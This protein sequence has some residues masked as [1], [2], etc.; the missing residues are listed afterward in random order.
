MIRRPPRSTLFPYTTLFRSNHD[1][2][3]TRVHLLA[4]EI[5]GDD[6]QVLDPAVGAAADEHFVELGA[7]DGAEVLD[8]VDRR[9][10]GDLRF[11]RFRV[12]LDKAAIHG[13]DRVQVEY[14]RLAEIGAS[15]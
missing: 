6:R 14:L 9:W 10:A 5:S 11:Q 2:P 13:R 3:G 7:F 4:L 8:I 12:D 15:V 1:R